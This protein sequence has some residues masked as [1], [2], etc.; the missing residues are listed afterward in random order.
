MISSTSSDQEIEK[1]LRVVKNDASSDAVLAAQL[2]KIYVDS[3][4]LYL[5][6]SDLVADVA[7]TG[8]PSSLSTLLCP[9]FLRSAGL[10]VP[11]LGVPGRPAG[12]IDSLAQVDGYRAGLSSADLVNIMQ[13]TGYAHFLADGRYAP[14]DARV[15]KLRQLHGAQQ[16]PTLVVASLLSKK[17]AVGV[18]LAG[19]DVRVAPHGNF[20]LSWS[21]ARHNAELFVNSAKIHDIKAYPVLTDGRFPY[22]PYIGRGEALVALDSIFVGSASKGLARHFEQCRLLSLAV[23]PQDLCGRVATIGPRELQRHFLANLIAQGGSLKA[24]EQ[25]VQLVKSKHIYELRALDNGFFSVFMEGVRQTLVHYQVKAE[26]QSDRFSD[27]VGVIL[28]CESGEWVRKGD[29]VA[30]VRVADVRHKQ[31]VIRELST[32]ICKTSPT[33]LGVLGEG[34]F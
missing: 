9:L 25:R 7:S 18:K 17:I 6:G 30:T 13:T 12:G 11:K 2:A 23:T 4:E 26:K 15:F 31:R 32:W 24:F 29:V 20:G 19:L 33:P 16:V 14:L 27:P 1:F 5:P 8:G 22:Q 21:D 3:G 10:A 28:L 34:V